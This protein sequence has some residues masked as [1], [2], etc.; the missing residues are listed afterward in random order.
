MRYL[1][2]IWFIRLENQKFHRGTQHHQLPLK[3]TSQH[4]LK[5]MRIG[6]RI[7]D[8]RFP[9]KEVLPGSSWSLEGTLKALN[10]PA[11]GFHGWNHLTYWIDL[12]YH[13]VSDV[14]RGL[15]QRTWK[16]RDNSLLTLKY[17]FLPSRKSGRKPSISMSGTLSNTVIHPTK[18]WRT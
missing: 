13:H 1:L 7:K 16:L 4:F 10:Q 18:N 15:W 6:N 8:S 3:L 11:A 14:Q 9:T 2:I 17:S 5:S 12:G